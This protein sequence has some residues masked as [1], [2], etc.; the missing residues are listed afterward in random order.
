MG[1]T[2]IS[3]TI[4]LLKLCLDSPLRIGVLI[5]KK[6][7]LLMLEWFFRLQIAI[8]PPLNVIL[9]DDSTI[10]GNALRAQTPLPPP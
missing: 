2:Q 1:T 5:T 6:S 4:K 9:I 8:S 7:I 10:R 3:L